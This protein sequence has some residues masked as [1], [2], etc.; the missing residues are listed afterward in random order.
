MNIEKLNERY[1][2]VV[3]ALVDKIEELL[4][5]EEITNSES[6]FCVASALAS[7]TVCITAA[8]IDD[9]LSTEEKINGLIKINTELLIHA[10]NQLYGV[11]ISCELEKVTKNNQVQTH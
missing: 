1:T 4:P 10:V 9:D 7:V 11:N 2:V 6:V 8:R 5:Y 3:D